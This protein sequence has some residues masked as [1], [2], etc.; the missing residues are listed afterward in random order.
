MW[1]WM[2]ALKM[3]EMNVRTPDKIL[4]S[5]SQSK[6]STNFYRCIRVMGLIWASVTMDVQRWYDQTSMLQSK[7][8]FFFL[9]FKVCMC[10]CM[11]VGAIMRFNC[12]NSV[13]EISRGTQHTRYII[14]Q[15]FFSIQF[16][17][18][19]KNFSR[20]MF[21]CFVIVTFTACG[22]SRYCKCR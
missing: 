20:S 14:D 10:V 18:Q 9:P 21:Y 16:G 17:S 12:A 4:K 7:K 2:V 6:V 22:T 13:K 15:E 11:W 3:S 1:Q 5:V 19:E 8:Q